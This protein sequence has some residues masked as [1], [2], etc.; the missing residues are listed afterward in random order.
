[1]LTTLAQSLRGG[2]TLTMQVANTVF[3]GIPLYIVTIGKALSRQGR[4]RAICDRT[5]VA[6][7]QG[8]VDGLLWTVAVTQR[9]LRW[10]IVGN[11]RLD[12]NQSYLL[13]ANHQSWVDIIALLQ[14]MNRRMPFPRFFAKRELL[15]LPIVG[16]A[17]WALDFPLLKRHSAEAV[18]QNPALKGEDLEITRKACEKYLHT[19]VTLINFLEGTR[20]TTAKHRQRQSSYRHLLPPKTGGVA[21][22]LES[23]PAGINTIIDVTIAYPDRVPDWWDLVCGRVSS[24]FVNV[25]QRP[26]PDSLLGASSHKDLEARARL[27]DWL[28]TIWKEKDCMLNSFH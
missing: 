2:A 1:M 23:M 15:W 7:T 24:V 11:D 3:W 19:T 18:A 8:W 28:E 6:I 10:E 22:A 13:V 25:Q 16:Q 27:R 5:L 9:Q 14:A 12:P 20:F 26:V 21:L 4:W 17:L